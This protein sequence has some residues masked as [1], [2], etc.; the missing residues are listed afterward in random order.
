MSAERYVAEN[1]KCIDTPSI[2]GDEYAADNRFFYGDEEFSESYQRTHETDEDSK[3]IGSETITP[4]APATWF[5]PKQADDEAKFR[6]LKAFHHDHH[7]I[8]KFYSFTDE[9]ISNGDQARSIQQIANNR[10]KR[11]D[12]EEFARVFAERILPPCHVDT[13]VEFATS[14]E[15]DMNSGIL[16][17]QTIEE[18]IIGICSLVIKK[19]G[20]NTEDVVSKFSANDTGIYSLEDYLE[21]DEGNSAK[22]ES[23]RK[24]W[25]EVAYDNDDKDDFGN[26]RDR[27]T[28]KRL[29]KIEKHLLETI[30]DIEED[31]KPTNAKLV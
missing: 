1:D 6:R 30:P 7:D 13:V 31:L 23:L 4:A 2:G 19:N 27:L 28:T 3:D 18:V 21:I 11:T 15:L 16:S 14:D 5:D 29:K 10:Q 25:N 22:I 26:W 24:K 17:S 12:D 9:Y 20:P 8:G